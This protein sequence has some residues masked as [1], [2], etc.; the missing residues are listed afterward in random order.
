MTA[1]TSFIVCLTTSLVRSPTSEP[2]G[3]LKQVVCRLDFLLIAHSVIDRVFAVRYDG[4][5]VRGHRV[6]CVGVL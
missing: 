5:S 1:S 3:I 6:D 4:S 2:L